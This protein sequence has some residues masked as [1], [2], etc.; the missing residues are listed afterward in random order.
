MM[1]PFD[2]NY[3]SIRQSYCMLLSLFCKFRFRT[4][5]GGVED[6]SEKLPL[7]EEEEIFKNGSNFVNFVHLYIVIGKSNYIVYTRF[8]FQ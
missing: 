2:I 5:Y 7:P 1:V 6:E 3:K 4:N 8:S